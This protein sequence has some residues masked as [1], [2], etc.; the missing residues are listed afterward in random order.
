MWIKNF[1]KAILAFCRLGQFRTVN[2]H[3]SYKF[4]FWTFD[5]V[6]RYTDD[7]L[8][9]TTSYGK[10][11]F[12]IS[13]KI[14]R[15][16]LCIRFPPVAGIFMGAGPLF[17]SSFFDR[18]LQQSAKFRKTACMVALDEWQYNDHGYPQRSVMDAPCRHWRFPEF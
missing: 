6:S 15:A 17:C 13:G 4:K 11:L 3:F 5:I 14:D 12:H 16:M 10:S 9:P 7:S 2:S 8:Q 1:L 18:N